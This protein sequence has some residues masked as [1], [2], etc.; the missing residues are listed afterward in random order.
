MSKRLTSMPAGS[1]MPPASTGIG[2][3]PPTSGLRTVAATSGCRCFWGGG[4]GVSPPAVCQGW[5]G[6]PGGQGTVG[7]ASGREWEEALSARSSLLQLSLSEHAAAA[8]PSPC[9]VA[10]AG[11]PGGSSCSCGGAL[12]QPPLAAP[13]PLLLQVSSSLFDLVDRCCWHWRWPPACASQGV[14]I[15]WRDAF[16]CR[17][18]GGPQY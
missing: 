14:A 7:T 6:A 2:A 4:S 18:T 13:A 1:W 5:R 3:G 11:H 10:V 9:S 16:G 12:P 8:A 15:V 17:A